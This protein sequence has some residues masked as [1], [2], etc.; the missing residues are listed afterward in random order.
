[1]ATFVE[2][3]VR[4][5]IAEMDRWAVDLLDLS[6]ERNDASFLVTLSKA[7]Q[8]HCLRIGRSEVQSLSSEATESEAAD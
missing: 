4:R 3:Y 2:K 5:P 7:S 1:M 8:T 6:I